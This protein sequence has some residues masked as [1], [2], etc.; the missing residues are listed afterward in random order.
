MTVSEKNKDKSKP[1]RKPYND[2]EYRASLVHLNVRHDQRARL[3]RLAQGRGDSMMATL[4]WMMD[5][6]EAA[7][8]R[9]RKEE[10]R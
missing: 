7:I 3:K 2:R 8:A 6:V 1:A 10:G 4:D 9:K 5:A